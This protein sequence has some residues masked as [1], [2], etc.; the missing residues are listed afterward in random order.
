MEATQPVGRRVP[1]ELPDLRLPPGDY[2][3]E[4]YALTTDLA[5][6]HRQYRI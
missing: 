6:D 4:I 3:F 2:A 5:L 1:V